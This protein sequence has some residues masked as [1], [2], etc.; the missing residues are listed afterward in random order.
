MNI[1]QQNIIDHYKNPQNFG[2]LQD[3]THSAKVSNPICGDEITVYLRV[4]DSKLA[5]ISYTGSGCAISM[6]TMSMLSEEVKGKPLKLLEDIDE[7]YIQEKMLGISVTPARL[8]C[9]L[10]GKNAILKALA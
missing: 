3:F 9:L 5:D 10:I 1:Y 6:S 7:K 8:S 2:E 4:E